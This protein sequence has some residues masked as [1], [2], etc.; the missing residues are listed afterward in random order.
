MTKAY[1]KGIMPEEAYSKY[2]QGRES[3]LMKHLTL[4]KNNEMNICRKCEMRYHIRGNTDGQCTA[5]DRKHEVQYDFDKDE[6]VLN[7][8]I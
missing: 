2:L 7:C 1:E 3:Y 6:N 4:M 5:D 8:E